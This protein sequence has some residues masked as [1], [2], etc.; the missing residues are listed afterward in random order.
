MAKP[1]CIVVIH[2]I[3]HARRALAA[4]AAAHRAVRLRSAPCGGAAWFQELVRQAAEDYP[5]AALEASLD[6]GDAPGLALG[7]LRQGIALVRFTGPRR[8]RDKIAA[9]A[10]RSGAAIDTGRGPALDLATVADKDMDRVLGEWFG[11]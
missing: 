3:D 11:G 6:C 4:A 8:T 5:G 7:A 2:G 9:I 10:K 1:P